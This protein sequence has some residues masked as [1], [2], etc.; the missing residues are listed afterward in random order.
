MKKGILLKS[1]TVVC[2]GLALALFPFI[3]PSTNAQPASTKPVELRLGHM[4]PVGSPIANHAQHWA[5][6]IAADSK[7]KLTIRIFPSDTLLKS[8]ELYDGVAKDIADLGFSFHRSPSD[9]PLNQ[10]FSGLFLLPERP[11]KV[12]T[13]LKVWNDVYEK[14]PQVRAEWEQVKVLWFAFQ[15][16]WSMHTKKP[17]RTLEDMKGLQIRVSHKLG[18]DAI[19]AWGGSPVSMSMGECV[20]ALQK[21][22]VG[23]VLMPFD[24]LFSFKLADILSC[25]TYVSFYEPLFWAAMNKDAYNRLSPELRKVIDNSIEWGIS[26]GIRTAASMH[27]AGITYA[28]SL[29]KGYEFITLTPQELQRWRDLL[30]P[31]Q[32]RW[33]SNLDAKGLPGTAMM[34]FQ[35]ERLKSY[36]K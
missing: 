32:D 2:L 12:E 31:V 22:T 11:N 7:G 24:G 19:T 30:K 28:K 18:A 16:A 8:P 21:G 23:G 20:V 17:V 14:F 29:N 1:F 35:R 33:A 25:S 36:T 10:T 15:A 3:A 5:D 4:F 13:V 34:Q 9:A 27:D 6:K 26:D